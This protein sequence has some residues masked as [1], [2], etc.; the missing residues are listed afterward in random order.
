MR[1]VLAA[2]DLNKEFRIE[3]DTSKYATGGV[4]PMQCSGKLWR[5]VAFISKLLSDTEKNYEIHDKYK[6][7]SRIMLSKF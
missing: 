1:P 2:P 3:V 6:R 5:P 7:T 4:F